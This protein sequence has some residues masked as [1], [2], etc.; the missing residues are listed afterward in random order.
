M[1]VWIEVKSVFKQ[2]ADYKLITFYTSLFV[3]RN[4]EGDNHISY[5]VTM[6]E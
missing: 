5:T 2:T 6:K 3:H 1:K 4:K